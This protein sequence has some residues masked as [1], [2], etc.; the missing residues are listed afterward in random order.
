[1]K[2]FISMEV[3][4]PLV[5]KLSP[6]PIVHQRV[7]DMYS[8]LCQIG[9]SHV[10]DPRN[11]LVTGTFRMDKQVDGCLTSTQTITTDTGPLLE[12]V[13]HPELNLN[14]LNLQLKE[15]KLI[16]SL[17]LEK[18]NARI[19]GMGIHPLLQATV[20]E[21]KKYRSPRS[22]YEYA[23]VQRGWPHEKLVNVAA[24]QEIVDVPKQDVFDALRVLLRLNGIMIFLFRNAP[25]I[26]GADEGLLSVR[27]KKWLDSMK[28]D[29]PHFKNDV[30]KCN[31][32]QKEF[33]GWQDYFDLL[34]KQFP[35]FLMG[36]KKQ[37]LFYIPEHPCFWEFLTNAPKDGWK[38]KDFNGNK[39]EIFPEIPHF[40]CLDWTYFGLT[41]PRWLLKPEADLDEIITAF[42]EN[43]IDEV[44][45]KLTRK[46][47]I[48]NRCNANSFPGEEM[49]S[50]AFVLGIV[51]N[52]VEAKKFVMQK[53][54]DFWYRLFELSQKQPLKTAVI[55]DIKVIDLIKDFFKIAQA[56]LKIRGLQEEVYLEKIIPVIENEKSRAEVVMELYHNSDS[57]ADMLAD[58]FEIK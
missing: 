36:T 52:I 31:I 21:Y 42:R 43:Q 47:V 51:E 37:G 58:K 35:M 41:R 17:V 39:I 25:D 49:A 4:Y 5:E 16:V 57:P 44:F 23:I 7:R 14:D 12:I 22:A 54:Y 56:G 15:L 45:K 28:S 11:K 29:N 48:E 19:L 1:M 13:T 26:F 6:H 3:E 38:A 53:S 55:D 40:D 8:L 34:L 2:R 32:P 33:T 46:I 9:W 30:F 27:P 50:V 10:I 24:I 18:I 20:D